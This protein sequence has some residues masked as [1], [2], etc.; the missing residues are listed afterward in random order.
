MGGV[1][2]VN[3]GVNMGGAT[4]IGAEDVNGSRQVPCGRLAGAAWR[5]LTLQ[6]V[7]CLSRRSF[8][9]RKMAAISATSSPITESS[10]RCERLSR[11]I[12]CRLMRSLAVWSIEVSQQK[13]R[14]E[15]RWR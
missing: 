14:M 13:T 3:M 6:S 4:T 5:L 15:T 1:V 7:S 2:G 11:S 8:C 12:A 9:I 10:A